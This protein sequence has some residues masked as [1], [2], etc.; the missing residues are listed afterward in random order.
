MF[1]ACC[2]ALCLG[3]RHL[4]EYIATALL[5]CASGAIVAGEDRSVVLNID[6]VTRVTDVARYR[7]SQHL[8]KQG[9]LAD[10]RFRSEP[11]AAALMFRFSAQGSHGAIVLG[12]KN[13]EGNWPQPVWVTRRTSG[14]R[15]TG[16]L[17]NRDLVIT[18]LGNPVKTVGWYR[19]EGWSEKALACEEALGDLS[20][21]DD[22]QAFA[23]FPE[24]V[25]GFART[26]EQ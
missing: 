10:I 5:L 14:V 3:C 24:W 6:S 4:R 1:S 22:R 8:I 9:C 23:V 19:G 2:R 12:A 18:W 16:E 15:S 13:R 20:L 25:H 21:E 7:L 17:E 26:D 11:E